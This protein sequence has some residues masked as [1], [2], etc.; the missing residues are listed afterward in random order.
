MKL[1]QPPPGI[2]LGPAEIDALRT[3][4]PDELIETAARLC[5]SD[6]EHA[7]ELLARACGLHW[8]PAAAIASL[9]FHTDV[10]TLSESRKR[11]CLM[12]EANGSRFG[13]LVDPFSQAI[14]VFLE[15]AAFPAPVTLTLISTQDF[16]T[17]LQ[18]VDAE[19]RFLSSDEAAQNPPSSEVEENA[20]ALEPSSDPSGSAVGLI[21]AVF[22]D[23]LKATASD[24]HIESIPLGLALKFRVDG[25][26]ETIR[27]VHGRPLAEQVLSRLKVLANLDIAERRRP[28]DG[29]FRVGLQGRIVDV[30]LSIMPSIHGE[31]AVLRLL[32]KSS[33]VPPG[34]QLTL[35]ALG[36]DDVDL[37]RLRALA[38]LPYGMLLVTGPTGS[39]KTTTLYAVLSEINTGRDKIVTIEDPVEY[40]LAGVLQVPVNEK[41][42]LTFAVGLRSILRHDPDRIM[43]G[44][45][46]DTETADIAVQAAL[47]GHLVLT[48][49]HANNVFDV[50]GRFTHMGIDPYTL[51][52]ALTGIW[53]QRLLR[54]ACSECAEPT[55]APD[56][57]NEALSM[58][59]SQSGTARW[60]TARGCAACRGTGYRGRL[61]IAEILVLDNDLRQMIIERR[62]A[63]ELLNAA[64]S[65][66]A[67]L[68]RE[69]AIATAARG[70]TTIDEVHRVTRND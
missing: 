31:D 56:E 28:Q 42:G 61:A 12:G 18:R 51:V 15:S 45:I 41:K 30:R 21:N 2:K 11:R 34:E 20:L 4:A 29:R 32:D 55:S 60:K 62:P 14:R 38:R 17:A 64:R 58:Q 7:G 52:S 1:E 3:C 68:L 47:T 23:A 10:I 33:L 35:E 13:L 39:G 69:A 54:R 36:F 16:E 27:V 37:Q 65:R 57:V 40:Q 25:L 53:A 26:L 22:L 63:V 44:E 19:H 59:L 67:R 66:G 24:I 8:L 48:T 49:V 70:L 43:V 6:R 46:R 5:N 9:N 50:I